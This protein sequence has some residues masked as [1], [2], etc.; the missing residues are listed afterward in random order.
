MIDIPNDYDED[1]IKAVLV[2]QRQ[3]VVNAYYSNVKTAPGVA[4]GNLVFRGDKTYNGHGTN[5]EREYDAL[6]RIFS[7]TMEQAREAERERQALRDL[8]N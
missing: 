6:S 2:S 1:Q 8:G 4:M 3:V 7:A 5:I